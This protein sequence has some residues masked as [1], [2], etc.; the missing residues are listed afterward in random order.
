M[1]MLP[2]LEVG[3]PWESPCTEPSSSEPEEVSVWKKKYDLLSIAAKKT[4]ITIPP[5]TA[6][7]DSPQETQAM[8]FLL[9]IFLKYY[10][11]C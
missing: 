8:T 4:L 1:L 2:W 7:K 3:V 10:T 5:Y 6:N 11:I 9:Q